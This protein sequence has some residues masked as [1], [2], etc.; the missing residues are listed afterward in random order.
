MLSDKEFLVFLNDKS[1]DESLKENLDRIINEELKKSESEMD[2]ELIEYCLDAL[3]KFESSDEKDSGDTNE[4]CIKLNFRKAVAIAAVAAVFLI[5]ALS[6]SYAA[7]NIKLFDG[8][9]EFYNDY[10]RINFDK[11]EDNQN[12]YSDPNMDLVKELTDN[13]FNTVLLP[14]MMFSKS[15]EIINIEYELG[16]VI[17]SANITFEHQNKKGSV[18][19][20]KYS[21]EEFVA[22]F[23][24]L[25][26]TSQIEKVEI[27]DITLY[28]FMQGKNASINYRDGLQIYNIII[29]SELNEAIEL[30]KTIK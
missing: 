5:G 14:K 16:E 20:T 13:G 4:K 26:V 1:V 18:F 15:Y 25:N 17:S 6:A 12:D 24:F 10:V 21:S 30:A 27:N 7:C 23:E 11:I 9:V 22:D 8:I 2:T 19:I 28:C 29:P 3:N